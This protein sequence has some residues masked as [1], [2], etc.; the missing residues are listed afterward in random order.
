[1][2][3]QLEGRSWLSLAKNQETAEWRDELLYEYYWEF[4]YPSTPTTFA[5]R[6]DDYKFITYHGVWDTEELYDIKNDPK[7]MHNLIHDERYLSII[8]DLRKRLFAKLVN[9]EGQTTV[10]YTERFSTGAVLR[11]ATRSKEAKFPKEWLRTPDANGE[12]QGSRTFMQRDTERARKSKV[13][14]KIQSQ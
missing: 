14:Q 11:E 8:A 4:N 9:N 10:P 12:I 7:E 1:M 6:T 5:L 2:P 3:K 13:K